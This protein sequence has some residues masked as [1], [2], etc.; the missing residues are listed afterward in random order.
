MTKTTQETLRSLLSLLEQDRQAS[1]A[2][3]EKRTQEARDHRQ[4]I[5]MMVVQ[6]IRQMVPELKPALEEILTISIKVNGDPDRLETNR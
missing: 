6:Q 4:A 2:M 5:G 3:I 1:V